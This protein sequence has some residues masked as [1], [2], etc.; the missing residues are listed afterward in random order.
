MQLNVIILRL[1]SIFCKPFFEIYIDP[2]L[3]GTITPRAK[4][5]GISA[6]ILCGIKKTSNDEKI[7][8]IV[9][10]KST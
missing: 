6:L 8:F 7:Q 1:S 5:W 3:T 2:A 4:R 9:V 10:K